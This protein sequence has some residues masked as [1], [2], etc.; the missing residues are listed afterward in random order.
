M[1]TVQRADVP[2]QVIS[3]TIFRIADDAVTCGQPVQLIVSI[4]IT[5]GIRCTN[6]S[7]ALAGNIAIVLCRG[8]NAG[9]AV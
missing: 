1:V 9:Y 7:P 4:N 5:I 2:I 3:D 8:G 6:S